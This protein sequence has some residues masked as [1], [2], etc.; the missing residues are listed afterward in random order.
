MSEARSAPFMPHG[1]EPAMSDTPEI[2]SHATSGGVE[3]ALSGA[4]TLRA[5]SQL[6]RL[7]DAMIAAVGD[8]RQARLDISALAALDTAGAWIIDRAR[9]TLIAAGVDASLVNARPEYATLLREAHFRPMEE[10][11][12][13][14][15]PTPTSLLSDIGESVH[16]AGGDL[17][18]GVEFFGRL[19][20]AAL[21]VV[22]VPSRWRITSF[23]FHLD[24][25]AFRGAPI[26]IMINFFVGAI[27]AQQGIFQLARFGASSFAVDLVGILTLR[28][29]G[30]LLTSI[31]V[32]GR[33]GSSITAEIGAMNMR[34]ELDALRV[35]ALDP[36]EVLVLPRVLA[37]VAALPIL[38]F[39]GDLSALFGGMC[40]TWALGGVT[41]E[42][43]IARLQDPIG[44]ERFE[45]GMFKAPFMALVIGIIAAAEGF[46]VRG[47]AESLGKNVTSSVV[48]SI[49]MV[50]VLDG[51]FAMFFVAV[52]F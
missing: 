10:R 18:S 46:T 50:I 25:I 21:R 31:M 43:F 51:I 7:G 40:A 30:V 17:L 15:I 9:Q 48:K 11:H 35:M 44:L 36:I 32:A 41:P 4:W 8:A 29:M 52:N 27:V 5:G 13:R 22:L 47:S 14:H 34:E 42:A 38:T 45:V 6:E 16:A 28:E 33:T 19:S 12:V 39:L 24:S 1:P 3:L 2:A 26:I 23:V 20:M 49:F 37:L